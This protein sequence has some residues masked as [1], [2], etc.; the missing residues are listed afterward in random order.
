MIKDKAKSRL[1]QVG[2][3]IDA[4]AKVNLSLDILAKRA[5]GY[6]ELQSVMQTISLKDR[7]WIESTTSQGFDLEISNASLPMNRDNLV[8]Q[9]AEIMFRHFALKGGLRIFL[10]KN[11]PIAAGL[12][13]GSSD[14]AAV[15]KAIKKLFNLEIGW[16]SLVKM[17]NELG[18]DVPFFL[19]GGT[20]LVEGRGELVK[21]LT[22]LP[23]YPLTLLTFPFGLSTAEVYRNFVITNPNFYSET[24]LKAVSQRDWLAIA[25]YAGNDLAATALKLNP[26]LKEVIAELKSHSF[27]SIIS[28]SGPSILIFAPF[29]QVASRFKNKVGSLFSISALS[30]NFIDDAE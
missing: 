2:I 12:G 23:P 19:K 7:L 14:A 4:P 11:I 24:I 9:A 15:L 30:R 28:G 27:K 21:P 17:A 3:K 29:K 13:G 10:E 26:Q 16:E 18:S 20:A 8:L 1:S 6:H 5:D 22:D 25:D